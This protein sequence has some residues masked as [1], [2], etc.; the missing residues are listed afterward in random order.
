MTAVKLT[1]RQKMIN[2]MYLV[3]TALLALNVSAEI[4]KSFH[5]VEL[6]MDRAGENMMMKNKSAIDMMV[7][8]NKDLPDDLIGKTAL[9]K[10]LQVKKISDE[11]VS[12]FQLLKEELV[13]NA[14]GRVKTDKHP[15]G[16]PAEELRN[17]DNTELHANIFITEGRGKQV[18]NKINELRTHLIN[19]LDKPSERMHIKS[20]LITEDPR[21][22][23]QTWES[24]MFE[25][26][27]LAAVIAL[28]SN[29]QNDIRNTESQV[30]EV[31]KNS[32]TKG[33]EAV[34]KL[35]PAIIPVNGNNITLGNPYEAKIFLAALSSRSQ[36]Q[37][38][39]NGKPLNIQDGFGKYEVIANHAGEN[40]YTAVITTINSDG[41]KEKFETTGSF[42]ASVPLA[43]ISATRMNVVY[44]GLD[45]PI[46]VSVPGVSSRDMKV[47]CSEGGMLTPGSTAG[48][49]ILRPGLNT[50]QH[51]LTISASVN[52]RLMGTSKYRI[53]KVPKPIPMLGSIEASGP[54]SLARVRAANTVSTVL[55][56]FIF[57]GVSYTPQ[58][59]VLAYQ[60]R[61]SIQVQIENGVGTAIS[62][63]MVNFLRNARPGDK[64]I[65]TS[66]IAI[67]PSG[68][69]HLPSSLVLDV[70]R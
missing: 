64:V 25:N 24:Q 29:I 15:E 63:R 57:D 40:R 46:S 35:V 20:D 28:L 47:S 68:P 21:L 36:P 54:V 62:G 55:K 18:R 42:F 9:T 49:Y 12:Y 58:S 41:E 51:D 30:L 37:I 56:D 31:L 27:P 33:L 53:R 50:T 23:S 26:A 59:W 38:E 8:Y 1:T 43:V 5:L 39:V 11:G 44:I 7:K 70:T 16:D 17:P 69:V 52:G 61:N 4:L 67:G 60:A 3:L 6:K 48:T 66:I 19:V 22:T 32:I 45:N 65:L 10:A 2:M 13:R 34:D 14:G